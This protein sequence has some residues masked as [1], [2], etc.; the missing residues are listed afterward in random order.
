MAGVVVAGA[1]LTALGATAPATGR[2]QVVVDVCKR[3][4]HWTHRFWV[5]TAIA[6]LLTLTGL[7]APMG[8][9]VAAPG[10]F[11]S[12]WDTTRV[13][14]GS[15]GNNQIR[16]PLTTDGTYNF[17]VDWGDQTSDAITTWDQAEVVHTYASPGTYTITINGTLKGWKF[18][19]LGFNDRNKIGNVSHWGDINL[20][21]GGRNF[22][23]AMYLTSDAT[24]SPDLTDTTDTSEMFYGA[25]RLNGGLSGW[26]ISNV[27]NMSNMFAWA[28]AFNGD[29][30]GWDTSNV[31]DMWGMFMGAEAFN[32]DI[33]GWNTA[34]VTHMS[35]MFSEAEAFNQ[36]IGGWNT[37]NVNYMNGMFNGASAFNQDIGDWNTASVTHMSG[38]FNGASRVQPGHR[39]LEHLQRHRHGRHVLLPRRSTRTSAAG[40]PAT[41]LR[42]GG[43][44]SGASAFNQD[45]GTWNTANVTQMPGMFNGASAFNQDIGTWNTG[46]VIDMNGMF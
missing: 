23:W 42:H 33:G 43:M 3:A 24:D 44:F 36:D 15:S 26:D 7:T 46:N 31:T 17:N 16:L 28:S 39:R 14:Q 40:T 22:W 32:Q 6:A 37:A 20:G 2:L 25:L 38:M 1:G 19:Y 10:D 12:T 30:S 45:I 29:L 5:A 13:E 4:G 27:T 18:S 11:V 34:N 35:G 21:N 41:S 8:P 9:A